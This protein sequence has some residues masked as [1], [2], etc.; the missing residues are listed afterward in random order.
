M[1]KD[2]PNSYTAGKGKNSE[3]NSGSKVSLNPSRYY[4]VIPFVIAL[5]SWIK[6][7]KKPNSSQPLASKKKSPHEVA[8]VS[9]SVPSTRKKGGAE[10][11]ATYG[12]VTRTEQRDG[13]LLPVASP[14]PPA[15]PA[16]PPIHPFQ[17]FKLR[18][19]IVLEQYHEEKAPS[20]DYDAAPELEALKARLAAR[21][22]TFLCALN[23]RDQSAVT[24]PKSAPSSPVPQRNAPSPALNKSNPWLNFKLDVEALSSAASSSS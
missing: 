19:S 12:Q 2:L 15:A 21:V 22:T 14:A 5:K 7:T 9:P 16:A 17:S 24:L 10:K 1:I 8:F 20:L 3:G 11:E 13:L 4:T 6:K 18:S 23:R